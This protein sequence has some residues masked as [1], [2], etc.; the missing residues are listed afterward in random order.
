MMKKITCFLLVLFFCANSY[1]QVVITE[2]HYDTAYNED[3][4]D[5]VKADKKKVEFR[6][7][8]IIS[9]LGEFIEIYNFSTEDIDISGWFLTDNLGKFEFPENTI[10]KSEQFLLIAYGGDVLDPYTQ[11]L[12]TDLLPKKYFPDLFPSTKGK[13]NQII[14]QNSLILNNQKDYVRL[15]AT[16]IRDITFGKAYVLGEVKWSNFNQEH[17]R[18]LPKSNRL[19]GINYYKYTT[20]SVR[21]RNFY[22]PSLQLQ[23]GNTYASMIATPLSAS[24]VPETMDLID[25]PELVEILQDNT[26]NT[27]WSKYVEELLNQICSLFIPKVEQVPKAVFD[28]GEL[29]FIHDAS[30]NLIGA[31]L[32]DDVE[33][34]LLVAKSATNLIEKELTLEEIKYYVKLYP[35]PTSGEFTVFFE[36]EIFGKIKIMEL[37]NPNGSLI[38]TVTLT[39]ADYSTNFNITNHPNGLFILK[40]TLIDNQMFSL[41]V[42]K[43]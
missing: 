12:I 1:G 16:K 9:H 28:K 39:A 30:G 29:C 20:E 41:N 14:Y 13:E 4:L 27:D 3:S 34:N 21:N 19:K 32:C 2:V 8:N 18:S 42:V 36:E 25:I 10:I 6:R 37:F 7:R 33:N 24:Y 38:E 5:A 40:F 26:A 35:N 31:K 11:E 17:T 43:K 15:F 23:R 22:T